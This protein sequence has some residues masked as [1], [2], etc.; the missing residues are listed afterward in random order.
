M[1]T[2]QHGLRIVVAQE[3]LRG[4]HGIE[5]YHV[6]TSAPART[7]VGAD[8]PIARAGTDLHAL[9]AELK[10]LSDDEILLRAAVAPLVRR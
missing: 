10:H 5:K 3:R 7:S 1:T 4:P 8:G 9:S 6:E 2:L